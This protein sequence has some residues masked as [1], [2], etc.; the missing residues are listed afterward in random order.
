MNRKPYPS[1]W[2]YRDLVYP[3]LPMLMKDVESLLSRWAEEGKT[4]FFIHFIGTCAKTEQVLTDNDVAGWVIAS[5]RKLDRS[6][7]HIVSG[8]KNT[9]GKSDHF[10][11]IVGITLDHLSHPID[12]KA[13]EKSMCACWPYGKATWLIANFQ[14]YPFQP[15]EYIPGKHDW[16][17]LSRTE[18]TPRKIYRTSPKR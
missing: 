15:L 4:G 2:P 16:V 14:Q 1:N 9:T 3:L 5:T 18:Y 7:F 6:V 10:H 13:L 11:S 12:Y 8:L 17:E